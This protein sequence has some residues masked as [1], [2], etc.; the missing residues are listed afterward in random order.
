MRSSV[1]TKFDSRK[2][3]SLSMARPSHFDLP[4]CCFP[5][6]YEHAA[7]KNACGCVEWAIQGE[8]SNVR[9]VAWGRDTYA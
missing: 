7:G 5:D 1:L 9:E 4:L 6:I 8:I 3:I 2:M